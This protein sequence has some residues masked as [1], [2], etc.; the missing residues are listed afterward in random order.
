MFSPVT[1]TALQTLLTTAFIVFIN[2]V[3]LILGSGFAKVAMKQT[4]LMET[5]GVLKVVSRYV[6]PRTMLNDNSVC[7]EV[8]QQGN[9]LYDLLRLLLMMRCRSAILKNNFE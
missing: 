3:I 8:I 2:R 9:I 7:Q 5:Q 1:K 6:A 4:T